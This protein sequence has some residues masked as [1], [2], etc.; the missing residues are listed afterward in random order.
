MA[1]GPPS[2]LP[3][4]PGFDQQSPALGGGVGGACAMTDAETGVV[5]VS[6]EARG[7]PGHIARIALSTGASQATGIVHDA[8]ATSLRWHRKRH[9]GG[10]STSGRHQSWC[11]AAPT[12]VRHHS[13]LRCTV[14]GELARLRSDEVS[15]SWCH[16]GAAV[17]AR[18]G[19]LRTTPAWTPGTLPTAAGIRD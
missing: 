7:V 9:Y 4:K 12:G 18:R 5:V 1:P 15:G 16:S 3:G 2:T 6:V 11:A 14:F 19:R 13:G 10:S 8:W 17:R